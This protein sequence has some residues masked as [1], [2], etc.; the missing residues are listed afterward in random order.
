MYIVVLLSYLHYIIFKDYVTFSGSL[1]DSKI[2]FLIV[3]AYLL[4]RVNILR[5]HS[6]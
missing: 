4:F 2:S 6:L 5:H 3:N 1:F